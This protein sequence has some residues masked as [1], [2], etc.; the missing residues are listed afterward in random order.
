M[1]F[2]DGL[3]GFFGAIFDKLSDLIGDYIAQPLV[4]IILYTPVP[5]RNGEIALV[6]KP[7]NGVWPQIYESAHTEILPAVIV[8]LFVLY[9]FTY[10]FDVLPGV[11]SFDK[12]NTRGNL[13]TALFL[14]WWSWPLGVAILA[15]FNGLTKGLA[16]DPGA[17]GDLMATQI[18]VLGAS[19]AVPGVN[20]I[21]LFVGL[22]NLTVLALA[23][24]LYLFRIIYLLIFMELIFII[25]A[26][27]LVD[28]PYISKIAKTSFS[29]FIKFAFIPIFAAAG[30]R[31]AVHLFDSATGKIAGLDLGFGD[32][33]LGIMSLI[34]PVMVIALYY[35]V[36][37]S[38]MG[39][40]AS[41]AASAAKK[42]GVPAGSLGTPT[43]DEY[44]GKIQE[45]A[46]NL[47]DKLTSD[48]LRNRM[49]GGGSA[50]RGQATLSGA[51]S[52]KKS[53]GA[54]LKSSIGSIAQGVRQSSIG[55]GSGDTPNPDAGSGGPSA[56]ERLNQQ[57]EEGER[58]EP[59]NV[60]PG[61][62]GAASSTSSSSSSSGTS[63]GDQFIPVSESPGGQMAPPPGG[64]PDR[65]EP[66][67]ESPGSS[68]PP[69]SGD[70]PTEGGNTG[71]GR[72]GEAVREG[73]AFGEI[74]KSYFDRAV[75]R[76][77]LSREGMR[78]LL[79][80]V[81][82]QEGQDAAEQVAK[83]TA[84]MQSA[85][86]AGQQQAPEQAT[87]EETTEPVA[88]SIPGSEPDS[89]GGRDPVAI[90]DNLDNDNQ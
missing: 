78:T 12:Q 66:S 80:N 2:W 22:T 3:F 5:T 53:R 26:V 75:E 37:Q 49:P 30:L 6:Q 52:G 20:V 88:E 17:L 76:S 23:L 64:E 63:E 27:Y 73:S 85:A 50:S 71:T 47:D 45:K 34:I 81:S 18:G 41:K 83:D 68:T 77:D 14:T 86:E 4:E 56:A 82:E 87:L 72:D 40:P 11:G 36:L 29:F 62:A 58:P 48:R 70:G 84:F 7:D 44:E 54:R 21:S 61:V 74:E 79:D 1:G 60:D 51:T 46:A 69:S 57:F 33:V 55:S 42:K 10:L 67:P 90:L 16:P 28:L 59:G 38:N 39:A 8:I 31:I 25:T 19:L 9:L 32:V 24:L 65:M 35:I 15:F 43:S 13:F 89:S